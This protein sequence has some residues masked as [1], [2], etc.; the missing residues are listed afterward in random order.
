MGACSLAGHRIRS[1]SLCSSLQ[2][3]FMKQVQTS[4]VLMVFSQ[5]WIEE[6]YNQVL[7]RNMLG[8]AGYWGSP[9][10]NS[11]PLITMLTGQGSMALGGVGGL[12]LQRIPLVAQQFSYLASSLPW[13]GLLLWRKWRKFDPWPGNIHPPQVQ[14]NKPSQTKPKP[15]APSG[16]VTVFQVDFETA[17]TEPPWQRGTVLGRC[18][19]FT[20]QD[21][22]A[23]CSMWASAG[24]RPVR[25]GIT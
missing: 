3:E 15:K 22:S 20:S 1:P 21:L 24:W 2:K 25:L 10:D 13:L 8:E 5:T 19:E 12:L 7:D 11:L 17:P 18:H 9:E 14:P 16:E 4:G 6:L 23:L